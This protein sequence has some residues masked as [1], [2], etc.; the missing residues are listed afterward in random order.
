MGRTKGNI[1]ITCPGKAPLLF[2][3]GVQLQYVLSRA[4]EEFG[5]GGI[6]DG[7]GFE[8]SEGTDLDTGSYTYRT[9]AAGWSMKV[10]HAAEVRPVARSQAL[11]LSMT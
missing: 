3:E 10:F 4:R 8:V 2:R 11:L 7:E 9:A 1:T 5:P 6:T